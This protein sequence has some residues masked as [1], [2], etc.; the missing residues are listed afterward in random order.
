M[1]DNT[2]ATERR[3]APFEL[4]ETSI[5]N[6]LGF[7]GTMVWDHIHPMGLFTQIVGAGWCLNWAYQSYSLLSSSIRKVE[8]HKDGK[9]LTLHP[10]IGSPFTC[11]IS[12]IEKLRHEKTLVETYEESFLFPIKISG[13]GTFHLHGNGQ[14]SIKNGELF[15]AIINGK[16]VKL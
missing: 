7:C 6:V 5:K 2:E 8:L 16:S 1:F 9:S 3:F 10:R 15:R 14:E 4:K 11:K 13:F 12:A